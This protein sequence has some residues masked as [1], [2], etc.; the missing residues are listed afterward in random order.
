MCSDGSTIYGWGTSEP[1]SAA[2]I[3]GLHFQYDQLYVLAANALL[4]AVPAGGGRPILP[5]S[6]QVG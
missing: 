5:L 6:L 3:V 1:W 2:G 4:Y